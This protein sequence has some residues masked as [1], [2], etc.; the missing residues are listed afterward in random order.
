MLRTSR[1]PLV[2]CA[3]L[4][5]VLG[6]V[7]LAQ[8]EAVG[9]QTPS[10]ELA[11]LVDMPTLPGV[12]LSPDRTWFAELERQ[13]LPGIVDLA[14]PEIGLAGTRI[15]PNTNGPSRSAAFTAIRLASIEHA[16]QR[17]TVTG[18]P[19]E[20]RIRNLSWS[21]AN[22]R[23]VFTLD[24]PDEIALYTASIGAPEATRILDR[25]LNNTLGRPYSWL[26]DGRLIVRALSGDRG[27]APQ[28]PLAS[29]GPNVQETTDRAAPAR[30]FQNLLSNAHDEALFD[31]YFTS[32]L[33]LVGLDGSATDL[34]ID[35]VIRSVAPSP[36]G[37]YLLVQRTERPYSYLVPLSRFP[38]RVTIHDAN[39][40]DLVTTLAEQPLAENIPLGFGSVMEGPR[41]FQWRQ[42][43]PSTVV[44]AEALDGGDIRAEADHRDIIYMLGAP[45]DGEPEDLFVTTLRYAGIQWTD[46]GGALINEFLYSTRMRRV[47]LALPDVAG[48]DVMMVMEY[49]TEDAYNDPGSPMTVP[50]DDGTPLVLTSE[51]GMVVYMA[52]QGASP[53]G[54]RPFVRMMNLETG[55]TRELFR[56]EDPYYEIPVALV[57]DD[58][59]H[60]LTRRESR[61]E[62]PNYFLRNLDT[63]QIEAI[64]SFT[65]PYPELRQI[66]REVVEYERSDG[67]PLSAVLYLPPDY[68]AERDGPL[69]TLVW[70]YPR[71]FASTAAAGQ[72]RDSPNQFTNIS[73]WGPVGMVLRGYAVLDNAAMP[74][75]GDEGVEPNDT[76]VEQLG[77]NAEALIAEG[78]RRGV[79]D[80]ERVAVGGHS[81][82]AFMTA[83]LLAHTDLFRAGIARSGAFNRSLT[84]FGFQREERTYWEAPDVYNTMSPFMQA[85]RISAPL[86]IIHGE[87]DDNSGTFP[88]Q[89]ERL[90]NAMNGLGGHARLVMLPHE[91]HGYRARESL[92]HML[93][94]T[95]RWLDQHV[96]PVRDQAAAGG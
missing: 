83:N 40:G 23:I 96:R 79:V 36:D 42:N 64:T 85:H 14:Q 35:G 74:I 11:S 48:S 44:W 43:A 15:N 9:Y 45:F 30:T 4:L 63:D 52:G 51:D 90:Y 77:M 10:P 31:H 33:L 84:P 94:E 47:T 16:D 88:M 58:G 82:G 78:A 34:G 1:T 5:L 6:P 27:E 60:L 56:S 68:D 72:R 17:V 73:H 20:A 28:M 39:T 80:P 13:A 25:S 7:A 61:T 37:R 69:P 32:E 57:G 59:R 22:D 95:E 55:E 19:D 50:D 65:D 2:I 53:E 49:S 24:Y 38:N 62:I 71:E 29:S 75:V 12:S 93:W 89:S 3:A 86:L 18:L 54:N 8:E 70:A 26:D 66:P 21:P 92:L 41:S 91:S 87:E 67:V 76:F 81:Y 46:A